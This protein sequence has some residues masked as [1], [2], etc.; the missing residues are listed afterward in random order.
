MVFA[1]GAASGF[2]VF[3][4]GEVDLT[5]FKNVKQVGKNIYSLFNF[6]IDKNAKLVRSMNKE[7]SLHAKH[8]NKM[9]QSNDKGMNKYYYSMV[10][11][12]SFIVIINRAF[13]IAI[14]Y[15]L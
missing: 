5:E 7:W 4:W 12:H 2:W 3:G 10:Y 6:L 8:V 9:V 13:Y 1:K 15:A 14:F 11:G